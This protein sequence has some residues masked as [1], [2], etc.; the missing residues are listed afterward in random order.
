MCLHQ[1]DDFFTRKIKFPCGGLG[2]ENVAGTWQQAV[3][4]G[5]TPLER[6]GVH[7]PAG[8]WGER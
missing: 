5:G 2:Q 8:A 3:Q 6:S 4:A 1:K 7:D